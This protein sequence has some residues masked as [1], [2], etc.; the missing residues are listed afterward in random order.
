MGRDLYKILELA[1]SATDQEINR[2]FK[3]MALQYH[4]D[5]N[6]T[7]DATE[8][9]QQ[10][11]DA[12][13]ILSDPEKRKIYD[14]Y[15][16][17]GLEN[18]NQPHN[19]FEQMFSS[20]YQH[21]QQPIAKMN[22]NLTLKELFSSKQVEINIPQQIDCDTCSATGYT[23]KNNHKC[24]TCRGAGIVYQDIRSGRNIFRNQV[25]CSMC[26]GTKFDI[27]ASHL[28]CDLC[29]GSG[30]VTIFETLNID[31][32]DD[33]LKKPSITLKEK[34]PYYNGTHLDLLISFKLVMLDNY[35]ILH[36]KLYF[37]QNIS[38]SESFCGFNKLFEHPSGKNIVIV[39]E[40]GYIIDP[41]FMYKLPRLG[42]FSKYKENDMYLSFVIDYPKEKMITF[43]TKAKLTF[44]N[45]KIAIDG[46]KEN[47]V[48]ENEEYDYFNV[49]DL[50]VIRG[51][52]EEQYF[53]NQ[54]GPG[55]GPGGCQ[56]Q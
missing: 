43:P 29:T 6:K 5:K 36:N 42:F 35:S 20:M 56:Q 12:H 24:G 2:A 47:I 34:G 55:P 8:K 7:S 51:E 15:G 22:H 50:E 19:P 54:E 10:I 1:N 30:K 11:N 46:K 41:Q 52:E 37:I 9:F 32:P 44:P 53:E 45:L 33:I 48:Y 4:P 25:Q 40:P 17:A 49:N 28:K 39:S 26:M 23:D 27:K 18:M 21:Q 13:E 16:E 14:K 3:K 31:L 38:F